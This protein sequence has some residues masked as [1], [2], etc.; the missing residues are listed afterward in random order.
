MASNSH[1]APDFYSMG[2]LPTATAVPPQAAEEDSHVATDRIKADELG[3]ARNLALLSQPSQVTVEAAER[4]NLHRIDFSPFMD[5]AMP[6]YRPHLL[7]SSSVH[8]PQLSL[9]R[10]L[11]L[12]SLAARQLAQTNRALALEYMLKSQRASQCD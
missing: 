12:Q 7:L 8:M 9:A 3:V 2:Y 11:V 10:S 4:V 1:S 6:L 5:L